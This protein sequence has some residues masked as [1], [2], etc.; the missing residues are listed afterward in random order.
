MGRKQNR[1]RARRQRVRAF[2]FDFGIPP[3]GVD[4]WAPPVELES[5]EDDDEIVGVVHRPADRR[6][7]EVVRRLP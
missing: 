4:G 5:V 7:R 2:D 3:P 1:K 6:R